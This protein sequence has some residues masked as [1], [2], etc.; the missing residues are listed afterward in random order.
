MMAEIS[1]VSGVGAKL[2]T[3]K[4]GETL[5]LLVYARVADAAVE[6]S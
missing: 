4:R 3:V 5:T 6:R 1:K 2:S